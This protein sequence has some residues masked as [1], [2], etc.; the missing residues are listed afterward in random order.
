MSR[1][2]TKL[3]VLI[4][5]FQGEALQWLDENVDGSRISVAGHLT[6]I[7]DMLRDTMSI[8]WDYLFCFIPPKQEELRRKFDGIFAQLGIAREQVIYAAELEEWVARN[9]LGFYLL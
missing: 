2:C 4:W 9:D 5:D 6:G 7:D 3:K 8:D 1:I